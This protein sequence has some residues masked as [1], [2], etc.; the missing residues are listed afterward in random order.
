MKNLILFLVV[1]SSL[2]AQENF[3]K[4]FLD[5][6]LRL[7]YYHYGNHE[8][9]NFTFDELIEEPYWGGSKVNLVDTF[10]YGYY[11]VKVFD[12]ESNE[13][14]YSRGYSTLFQEWQ[15]TAEAKE[16]FRTYPGAVVFPFPKNKVRVEIHRRN[17]MNVFE[18][19]FEYLV[20]PASYFI[21][22]E[23]KMVFDNFKVHYS[24]DAAERLDILLLPEGYSREEADSF[25]T[26]CNI[27]AQFLFEYSPFKE[28]KDNINVWGIDACSKDSGVD[29][30]GEH[31]WKNSLMNSNYYTFDSERYLMTV[32]FQLVRDIA[33]NAPYD[34]IYILANS[35]KYGG[36]AIYNFYSL[37]A[38]K[39][40]KAKQVFI[41]ELGHGLAG[42][43]DEYGYDNTYQDMYPPGVEP[44]EVN[45]TTL[46]DFESKWKKYVDTD[47]PIPTPA[48]SIYMDKLGAFEGAGYV[49]KGVY[50]PTANSI[51]RAF[52]SNE[53]NIVCKE[54]LDKVIKFYAE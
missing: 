43:A 46:V 34:Q 15:T 14:I 35:D 5:K 44:W 41:H 2:F 21:R 8:T 42:L 39:N 19:K 1:F 33:A 22:K 28:N 4:Y 49:G 25:K 10:E 36:G 29:I 31:I 40:V 26:D 51:M 53:F 6:T 18:K 17:R 47:T 16:I 32:D 12:A 45:I 50:R 24:G 27:F 52:D 13:L 48:D 30:P 7:D 54:V 37:T 38:V 9:E 3:D 23:R 11:M 20:D